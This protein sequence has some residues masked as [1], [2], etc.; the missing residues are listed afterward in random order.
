MTEAIWKIVFISNREVPPREGEKTCSSEKEFYS[1]I[2][3]IKAD[4]WLKFV[5]GI[6][7]NGQEIKD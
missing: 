3:A 6:H 5:K 4:H 7:P 1:A 2:A